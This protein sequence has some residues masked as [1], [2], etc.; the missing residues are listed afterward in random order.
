MRKVFI[1]YYHGDR[2][3]AQAFVDRYAKR[4]RIFIPKCIGLSDENEL[5]QSSNDVYI[6]NT[7]RDRLINDSS[8]QI[9]LIGPCTHGRKFIDLEIHRSLRQNNGLIGILLSPHQSA[10]LP[11]RFAANYS[12]A[13]YRYQH[14]ADQHLSNWIED[15]YLAR[16]Q[17]Q[18]LKN[19][20]RE[21]W[22]DN[23]QCQTCRV[24]H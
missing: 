8:V 20:F 14:G 16:T 6:L 2:Y 5:I 12:Y 15:A 1:S 24:T 7:I 11:E 22:E 10:T 9:V 3:A 23:R 21:T 17:R 4:Q 19:N 13:T 18:H